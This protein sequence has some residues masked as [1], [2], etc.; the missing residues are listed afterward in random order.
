MRRPCGNRRVAYITRLRWR[1][2]SDT[3]PAITPR[4]LGNAPRASNRFCL[5]D[6]GPFRTPPQGFHASLTI[7][8]DRGR[9]LDHVSKMGEQATDQ[10]RD[11]TRADECPPDVPALISASCSR[12]C[13]R[14]AGR[15]APSF[16][17][18]SWNCVKT[19]L[20]PHGIFELLS[21]SALFVG[22]GV[23]L[24]AVVDGSSS[25]GQFLRGK[26]SEQIAPTNPLLS[27]FQ[28]VSFGAVCC[29]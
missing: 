29:R 16:N 8:C 22:G 6:R 10:P 23:D 11:F 3:G 19:G 9:L 25:W 26:A 20:V 17:N 27:I 24:G 14:D 7:H 13:S 15:S 21:N 12:Y 4:R 1:G 18:R 5:V 28:A 2:G